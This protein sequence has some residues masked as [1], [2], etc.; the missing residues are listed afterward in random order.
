MPKS[1]LSMQRFLPHTLQM[2]WVCPI[3]KPP[4][5]LVAFYRRQPFEF[6]QQQ[7]PTTLPNSFSFVLMESLGLSVSSGSEFN[8]ATVIFG[9]SENALVKASFS[10][11]VHDFLGVLDTDCF[12]DCPNSI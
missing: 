8:S 6:Y 3:Q 10:A 12:E 5:I 2:F 4:K 11:L 7:T 1:Q 9:L